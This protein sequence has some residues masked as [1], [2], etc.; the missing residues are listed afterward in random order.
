MVMV[1]PFTAKQTDN[2]VKLLSSFKTWFPCV[3]NSSVSN[4][5]SY[6]SIFMHR[7]NLLNITHSWSQLPA[8]ARCCF[9]E[10]ILWKSARLSGVDDYYSRWDSEA[11]SAGTNNMFYRIMHDFDVYSRFRYMFYCEP[12]VVPIRHGWLQKLMDLS[13]ASDAHQLWMIGSIYRGN[14]YGAV[15]SWAL[16]YHKT[17][18]KHLNG[19]ALYRLGDAQFNE[20]LRQ[21]KQRYY[22]MSF[23]LSI[24]RYFCGCSSP[25]LLASF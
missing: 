14:D 18:W 17:A 19:N 3:E 5:P 6:S 4:A 22:P 13:E 9:N 20:F 2:V 11:Y 15:V 10:T 8:V 16:Q 25:N 1:V 23:D 12:D 21:V 24:Y 7:W